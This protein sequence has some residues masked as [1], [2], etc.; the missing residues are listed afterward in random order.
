MSDKNILVACYGSLRR[1]MGNFGCN[2]RAGAEFVGTGKTVEKYN[3]YDLG[4]FPSISLV[5]NNQDHRVVVDVFRTDEAG[6]TGPYDSLEGYRGPDQYNFYNRTVV[7]IEMDTGEVV[8][9]QI[10]HIDEEKSHPVGHGDWCLHHYGSDY[11]DHV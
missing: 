2:V 5:H 6:L 8:E 3:L 4:S 1:N 10:Y 11:Y 9:A 7:Q